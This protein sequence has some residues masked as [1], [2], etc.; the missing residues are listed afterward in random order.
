MEDPDKTRVASEFLYRV[1]N[2]PTVPET[3]KL[4]LSDDLILQPLKSSAHFQDPLTDP[5]SIKDLHLQSGFPCQHTLEAKHNHAEYLYI[6]RASLIHY[7]FTSLEFNVGFSIERVGFFK[8][9]PGGNG[10]TS[11]VWEE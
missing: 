5:I 1:L 2:S 3:F 4:K 7:N 6:P 8:L 9:S 10:T 11:P